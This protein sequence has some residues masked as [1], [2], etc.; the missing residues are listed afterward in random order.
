MTKNLKILIKGLILISALFV[1]QPLFGQECSECK[2]DFDKL[3][4]VSNSK[5]LNRENL[6]KSWQISSR[7]Y[8][9][10][11]SE[12]VGKDAN[13]N[14]YVIST[15]SKLFADICLK[16][17]EHDCVEYYLR[18]MNLTRGSAEEETSFSLERVFQ[19]FPEAILKA[20][21]DDKE[22]LDQLTWGFLNNRNII[23]KNDCKTVFYKTYPTLKE[24]YNIYRE[25]IDYII[26]SAELELDNP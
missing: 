4:Q 20:I 8:K 19:K 18:Y 1:Y 5:S 15:L 21:G 16:A 22:I 24:K 13:G 6:E 10:G 25:S 23:N 12:H 26:K 2:A 17:D 14:E 7:L 9:K 3:L 11:Y